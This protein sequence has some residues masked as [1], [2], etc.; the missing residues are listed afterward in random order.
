M[1]GYVHYRKQSP[2]PATGRP[3][4]S[5]FLHQLSGGGIPTAGADFS[6]ELHQKLNKMRCQLRRVAAAIPTA[7]AHLF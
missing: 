6:N 2:P 5:G 7:G 3:A 1:L 4:Q